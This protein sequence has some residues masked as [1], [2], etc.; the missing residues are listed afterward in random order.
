MLNIEKLKRCPFCGGE[1]QFSIDEE[2]TIDTEGRKWGYQVVCSKCCASTGLCFSV[3]KAI[4]YWNRR[5][6][7]ETN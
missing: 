7:N 6:G 1:T 4:E 3:E 2:A 5:V